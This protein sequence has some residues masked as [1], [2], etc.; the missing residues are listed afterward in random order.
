MNPKDVLAPRLRTAVSG[1]SHAPLIE[2]FA[3]YLRV[4]RQ[5]APLTIRNY[6]GDLTSFFEYINTQN[7]RRL[8]AA[9]RLFLRS[10]LAWL[11]DTGYVRASIARKL[12]ALR[13]MYRFLLERGVVIQDAT[14]LVSAPKIERRLPSPIAPEEVERLLSGPDLNQRTGVRDRALLELL[15]AAG[16]RVSE[17]A[18]LNI[19]DVDLQAREARVTG[20]GSKTRIVLIGAQAQSALKHYI[21]ETRPTLTSK[22]SGDALFLSRSGRRLSVR[23]IQLRIKRYALIAGLDPSFH[24]HSLRHS[25]A[26]HLL[27][28]GADLRVVQDLLGHASPQTTQIYTQVSLAKARSTYLYA[29]PRAHHGKLSIQQHG[30]ERNKINPAKGNS[31]INKSR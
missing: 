14:R 27:D 15:Y 17:A 29:H 3:I 8:D 21:C 18:S 20:K 24:T 22:R 16:L 10:Y 19:R 1:T 31:A 7:L 23:S 12:S 5:L 28:G 30:A 13:V 2:E 9:N 6:L 4:T 11:V 26:T 25:F